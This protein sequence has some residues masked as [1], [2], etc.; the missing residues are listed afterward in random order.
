MS[1][2]TGSK[3][4]L[5]TCQTHSTV[6]PLRG[7]ASIPG[8]SAELDNFNLEERM[9]FRF[10][11]PCDFVRMEES[12]D[13]LAGNWSTGQNDLGMM[14]FE[15]G[16]DQKAIVPT[17]ILVAARNGGMHVKN[18]TEQESILLG[19]N[20]GEPSRSTTRRKVEAMSQTDVPQLHY[21]PRSVR[22]HPAC[23]QC[24]RRKVRCDKGAPCSLCKKADVK[25]EYPERRIRT[26]SSPRNPIPDGRK[27]LA[28][29][30]NR[31]QGQPCRR[32][33]WCSRPMKHPGHCK[34]PKEHKVRMW[35]KSSGTKRKRQN[36]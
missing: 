35:A 32:D 2:R 21:K 14:A 23:L 29:E 25:C 18:Y 30:F 15:K 13:M 31:H 8:F 20:C 3:E 5:H 36:S 33:A 27:A 7:V 4:P 12:S 1:R 26:P 11:E 17:R 10:E 6:T 22:K 16:T 9:L 34:L 24:N 28:D 19:Q